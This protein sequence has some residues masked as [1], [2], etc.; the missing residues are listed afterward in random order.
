MSTAVAAEDNDDLDS[1][2]AELMVDIAY[3]YKTFFK[4]A[5][6]SYNIAAVLDIFTIV[7]SVGL[8]DSLIRQSL[9][10]VYNIY[11]AGGIAMMSVIDRGL[12]F[13]KKGSRYEQTADAYNS[14]Y[15]DFR[16][17]RELTLQNEELTIDE[18]RT[19]LQHLADRQQELNELTPSTW[20]IAY[21]LLDEEDV[22]GNIEVTEEEE[23][24]V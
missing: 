1:Y 24:R 3:T 11:L 5:R 21:K 16:E 18:K 20:D 12:N 15:K 14:L 2:A 19:K 9:P 7:A 22:L 4:M 8:L 23:Q 6:L 13:N 17:F 10:S